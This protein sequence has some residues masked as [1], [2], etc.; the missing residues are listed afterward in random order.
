[1][2]RVAIVQARMGSTRLPGKVLAPLAG[3]SMLAQLVSRLHR[4]RTLDHI[5]IATTDHH[6]D[7]A[8][9]DEAKTLATQCVRGSQHDV[10]A[11]YATA[12]DAADADVIVRI[13]AD[14]PLIDPAVV[15]RI[16]SKLIAGNYDYAS[17]V[18]TR[19]FP[20]GLDCEAFHADVLSR[21]HRMAQSAAA[22]EHVTVYIRECPE[23]FH[24][25]TIVD[26]TNNSD[27]RWTVDT[28]ADLALATRLYD[29]L[30][31]A[32]CE[33]TYQDIVAHCRANPS[34]IAVNAHVAQKSWQTSQP[35]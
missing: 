11:R 18:L 16:V 25:A 1:M 30:N 31:L 24:V 8:I 34:I 33:T 12:A 7:N 28:P 6:S 17:N 13:T 23:L 3:R 15:D 19:T 26:D 9:E 32:A 2:N 20:L 21:L 22:R 4:C 14:C 5:V 29:E 35:L 10:L 27:L